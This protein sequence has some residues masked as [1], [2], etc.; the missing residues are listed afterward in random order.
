VISAVGANFRSCPG[1]LTMMNHAGRDQSGDQADEYSRGDAEGAS[2]A[3]AAV[4]RYLEFI[5]DP[6]SARDEQ[7]IEPLQ[8]QAAAEADVIQRLR[9]LSALDRARMVDGAALLDGFVRHGRAWADANQ[10]T[11]GALRAVGVSPVVLAEAGFDLGH[12]S[13]HDRAAQRGSR[14]T[15]P[16]RTSSSGPAPRS[17]REKRAPGSNVPALAV[18]EWAVQR[19]GLFTM[20]E[21]MAAVGASLMTVKKA[22]TELLADGK[23]RSHGHIA[24][25]GVRGRAPEHF[26][27]IVGDGSSDRGPHGASA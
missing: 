26:S 21:A 10:I 16:G 2:A 7:L 18:K 20:A 17:P 24:R 4:R 11:V 5:A 1:S 27:V 23:I 22:V 13:I 8:A 9:L 3:T 6:E 15:G 12:G 25:P 14:S 19:T